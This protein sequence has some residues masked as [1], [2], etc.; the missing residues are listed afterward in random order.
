M[1]HAIAMAMLKIAM[2]FVVVHLLKMNAAF[3]AAMAHH[4]AMM[5]EASQVD[6]IFL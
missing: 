1:A 2:A 6:A 4:A 3:A 5:A